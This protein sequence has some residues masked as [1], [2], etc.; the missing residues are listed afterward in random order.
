MRKKDKPIYFKTD[1]EIEQMRLSCDLVS[2]TLALVAETLREGLTGAELD[3]VA[4]TFI[5]DHKGIPVFKG[6]SGFP[7]SLCISKNEAIVH[8][9]PTKDPFK[10]GDI[11]S[12]DCGTSLNGWVGDCA[13]TFVIGRTSPEVAKLLRTTNESLYKGIEQA[14]AGMRIGDISHAIQRYCESQRYGVVRELVGH[15]VGRDLHEAPEVP[16]YGKKGSGLFLKNGLV[17][18]I[19]PMVN[20]G[21]RNVKYL[22]DNWTIVTADRKPS[23]H[24]EHTIVVR[25]RQAE[26]L[27]THQ[28]IEDAIKKNSELFNISEKMATFA[29]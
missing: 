13:Y 22:K 11:V 25:P 19:E 8:G 24:F 14:R 3:R 1:E 10:E 21:T 15:G 23:A 12:V 4:E 27:T 29:A 18:A 16:N 17:I 2:R 9:V 6:Y 20:L 26:I 28:F 7:G 5:R